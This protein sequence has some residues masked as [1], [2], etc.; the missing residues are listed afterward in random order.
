MLFL[1]AYSDFLFH[2]AQKMIKHI[3]QLAINS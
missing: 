1:G 2:K 3:W